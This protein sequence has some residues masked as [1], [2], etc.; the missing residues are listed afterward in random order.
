ME[1]M[2][3]LVRNVLQTKYQDLPRE[4]IDIAKL[5]LLDTL[6][7]IIAG[8]TAPGC[9]SVRELLVDW[10]GKKESTIM[11]HGDKVPCPNAAFVN[12][13]M[14][15]ALDFDSTWM[16]GMHMSAASIP[17]VLATAEMGGA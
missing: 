13:T 10:G 5:A 6:G 1:L 15:R 16:G 7:C 17:T 9:N 8:A 12:S 11:V 2:Q 4:S 3:K 14:A